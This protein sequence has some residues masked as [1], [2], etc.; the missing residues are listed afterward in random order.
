M[1]SASGPPRSHHTAN[2]QARIPPCLYPITDVAMAGCSHLEQVRTLIAAGARMIEIREKGP[3]TAALE[4][5]LRRCVD[6]CREAGVLL[7]INDFADLAAAIDADGV[8]LGQHDLSPARA[9]RVLA[10]DR[11]IGVSTHSQQQ[12][13]EALSQPVDYIAVGPVFGTTTK[14]NPDPTVGLELVAYAARQLDG[15]MPL[16]TIGGI[17]AGNLVSVLDSALHTRTTIIPSL[18]GAVWQSG[19]PTAN[20]QQLDD[21]YHR[22]R[23]QR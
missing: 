18:I 21:L 15:R 13:D 20:F 2:G 17:H 7:I 16:V 23:A 11:I 4:S 1:S 5:Q 14:A 9:R 6:I 8:H 12:F 10:Q 19:N 22:H 3:V